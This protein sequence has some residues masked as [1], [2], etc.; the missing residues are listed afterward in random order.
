MLNPLVKFLL[1]RDLCPALFFVFSRKKCETFAQAITRSL[2]DAQEQTQVEK[3]ITQEMLKIE[4]RDRFT[5]LPQFQSLKK[6]LMKGVSVHHSGLLPIF[7]EIV[8]I[9]FAQKLVKVLFAT[10]T[11]AVGVN[12]PT[13]TVL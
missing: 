12:M 1:E 6:M 13:K 11:F 9:L 7:K 8:E 10:E 5:C 3:I 2:I 4:D